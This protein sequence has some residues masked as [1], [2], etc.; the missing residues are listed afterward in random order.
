MKCR[1]PKSHFWRPITPSITSG[2]FLELRPFVNPGATS[3]R[4]APPQRSSKPPH[5]VCGDGCG[6]SGVGQNHSMGSVM[7]VGM[8]YGVW[9]TGYGVAVCVRGYGVQDIGYGVWGGDVGYGV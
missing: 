7:G 3:A 6:V 1:D 5:R 8:G 4:G 2:A 9:D